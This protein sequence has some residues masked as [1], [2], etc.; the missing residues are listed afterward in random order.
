V[1]LGL[2]PAEGR[3]LIL[4][5]AIISIVLNPLVFTGAVA[6][7][8]RRAPP[9]APAAPAEPPSDLPV[10]AL[11]EHTIVVGFGRVGR[12]VARGLDLTGQPFLVI[13][14][15]SDACTQARDEG[16]EILTG[17]AADGRVLAAA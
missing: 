6:L 2:L 3:D 13:E 10:T 12:V 4:A 14:Y 16:Y 7:A 11:S 5:A 15:R 9:P 1:G 8:R 17:N